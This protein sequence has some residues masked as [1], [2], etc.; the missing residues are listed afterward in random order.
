MVTS[1]P[2]CPFYPTEKYMH[3]FP[4]LH[5]IKM[6]CVVTMENQTM[7]INP[8][9]LLSKAEWCRY[10]IYPT[11][12]NL[13]NFTVAEAMGLEAVASRPPAVASSHYKILSKSIKRTKL[14]GGQTRARAHIYIHKYRQTD[15]QKE[16]ETFDMI[17]LLS[18]FKSRQI[19]GYTIA[20]D[21]WRYRIQM[22]AV[23]EHFMT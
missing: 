9:P 10:C 4:W 23:Q 7:L 15:R 13:S 8:N 11:D 21:I 2:L 20:V 12:L 16:R 1:L 14:L 3:W 5:Q 19:T 22:A 18:F 17:S 6:V